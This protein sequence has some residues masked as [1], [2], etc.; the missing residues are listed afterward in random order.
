MLACP[1][2]QLVCLLGGY[3]LCIL[4]TKVDHKNN[5]KKMAE[6]TNMYVY[7]AAT[8]VGT[9]AYYAYKKYFCKEKQQIHASCNY[10]STVFCLGATTLAGATYLAPSI[11]TSSYGKFFVTVAYEAI[12]A[13]AY[14][15]F[16][17]KHHLI[18]GNANMLVGVGAAASIALLANSADLVVWDCFIVL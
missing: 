11:V 8:L 14:L 18:K 7:A 10:L 6:A 17:S 3:P 15:Y 16:Q 2:L 9:G 4:N 5:T 12:P 1:I 13:V